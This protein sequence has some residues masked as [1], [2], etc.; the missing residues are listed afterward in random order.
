MPD[1]KNGKI[2]TIRCRDDK[3]LIYVGSTTQMLS[4]R[5]QEHKRNSKNPNKPDY[6]MRVYD[7]MREKGLDNFYIELHIECPCE[8][9]EQLTKHEG[10]II[11]E[12]GTLNSRIP[13]RTDKERYDDNHDKCLKYCKEYR[14]NNKDKTKEY[15]ENN[16][17]KI[18]NRITQPYVCECGSTV[19]I[20]AIQ[21]HRRSKKHQKFMETKNSQQDTE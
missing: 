8:N 10:T 12:I 5:W 14:E 20:H 1:Y 21:R 7:I 9:K 2:Y 17:E 18:K 6:K 19:Q 13:G 16:K 15:R 4:Q 3:S 11:R